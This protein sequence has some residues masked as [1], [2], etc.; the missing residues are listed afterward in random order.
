MAESVE[1]TLRRAMTALGHFVEKVIGK[2]QKT[3]AQVESRGGVQPMLSLE[4]QLAMDRIM[5]LIEESAG[6]IISSSIPELTGQATLEVGEAPVLHLPKLLGLQADIAIGVEIGGRFS[7]QQGDVSR[8]L[9]IHAKPSRL[10]FANQKFSYIIGRLATPHQG[11]VAGAISEIGRVLAPG[12][13]GMIIDYHPFGLYAKRGGHRMRSVESNIRKI[14]EYYHLCRKA[15]LR[16]VDLREAFID[17]SMRSLFKEDEI[18][19]YRSLKGT[20]LLVFLFI[21]KLKKKTDVG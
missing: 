14:E 11:D 9:I 20:P 8:G 3:V 4:S 10:P 17:E 5:D 13:R 1:Q 18:P 2:A 16:V 12:G 15:D 6:R 7:E 21:Y 19:A